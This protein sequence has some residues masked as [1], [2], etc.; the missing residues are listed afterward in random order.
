MNNRS[1][2]NLVQY[3]DVTLVFKIFN[4]NFIW[5]IRCFFLSITWL[6]ALLGD[7][8]DLTSCGISA[9]KLRIRLVEKQEHQH[10][11]W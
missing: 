8:R 11:V 2:D 9:R 4:D 6:E 7:L 3:A 5:T 1:W 10:D